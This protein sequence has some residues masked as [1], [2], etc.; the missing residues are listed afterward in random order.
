[1]FAKIK[2]AARVAFN[3]INPL[4][5]N[6]IV[7]HTVPEH[8]AGPHFI[9]PNPHMVIGQ[10]AKIMGEH[11]EVQ[12]ALREHTGQYLLRGIVVA[13]E[14]GEV[15]LRTNL[16][17]VDAGKPPE[18]EG[19]F[20]MPFSSIGW[21]NSGYYDF[22]VEVEH[23]GLHTKASITPNKGRDKVG[24]YNP[25]DPIQSWTIVLTLDDQKDLGIAFN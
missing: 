15:E 22:K 21:E 13:V 19:M 25:L 11:R 4:Y 10:L 2:E 18:V 7:T 23:Q 14:D 6:G 16:F 1:M 17:R 24:F 9:L 20:T 12:D 3:A 5:R 8:T